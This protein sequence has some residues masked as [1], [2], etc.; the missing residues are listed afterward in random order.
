MEIDHEHEPWIFG[1]PCFQK[2]TILA[3]ST[4]QTMYDSEGEN[5][6]TSNQLPAF[7]VV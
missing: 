1:L 7:L 3:V 5:S 2:K 4:H 6:E